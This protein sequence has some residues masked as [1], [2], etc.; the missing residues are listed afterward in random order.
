MEEKPYPTFARAALREASRIAQDTAREPEERVTVQ[1]IT[2]DGPY[3][4]D[5]DDAFWLEHQPQGGYRLH[6]SIADVGSLITPNMT[7]ALDKEA[8]QRSFTR[9]YAERNVPMLPRE[10]SE[11]QLS[12]LPEQLRPTITISIPFD[13]RL[14]IGE[15]EIQRTSLRSERRFDYAEVDAEIEHPR[16][17]FAPMLQNAYHIAWRLL[18][19]RRVKGALAFYDLHAGWATTEEG[20]LIRLPEGQRHKAQII[21]QEWMI[22]TNQSLAL[23]F[24][25]RGLPALYRNH[26]A[27]AIAPERAT[28]LEMI[29]TAVTHAE[30]ARIERVRTTVNLAMERARYA[31]HVSGHFGLNLPAYLHMTSPL[32]RYPDLVNQRILHAVFNE[33]PPPYTSSDLATIAAHI[34]G[35][36]DKIREARK[37]HFLAEYL[38]PIRKTMTQGEQAEEASSR[39]F[40]NLD[41]RTFHSALKMAA[42]EHALSPGIEQEIYHRLDE[43]QLSVHDIFTLVFRF[44]NIGEEWDRITRASL[45]WLE[46]YPYHAV[47]IYLMG[48]QLHGWPAPRCDIVAIGKDHQRTFQASATALVDGQLYRSSRHSAAQKDLAKQYALLEIVSKIANRDNASTTDAV[49][50]HTTVPEPLQAPPV[51]SNDEDAPAASLSANEKGRLLELAQAQHWSKP[52]FRERERLGPPHAPIFAVEATIT[53]AGQAYAATGSGTTKARAQ[54]EAARRLRELIAPQE[55]ARRTVATGRADKPAVSILHEMAQKQEIGGV[56]YTYRQTG[57][58]NDATFLCTCVVTTLDGRE[59]AIA[60]EGKTKKAAAQH[61]ASQAIAALFPSSTEPDE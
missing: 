25:E 21:I 53:I 39:P 31:P 41:A 20:T 24:A 59:I 35:E 27:K 46:R 30:Q 60:A 12:L 29:T 11:G 51:P 47:S 61:A 49:Q 28:L 1:G 37:A 15:L 55:A 8:F 45:Q 48:Q 6:I 19:A 38:E 5:L 14:R 40:V 4:K 9:Y 50:H 13:E 36:E 44:Q 18:Q 17:T 54:Q 43:Q 32:R 3:S 33:E 2:I 16:T 58:P 26:A 10:L 52:I 57:A 7:P 42:Q 34:N 56:S 23:Y 22:L